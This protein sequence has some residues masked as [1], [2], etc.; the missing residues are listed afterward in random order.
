MQLNKKVTVDNF[1]ANIILKQAGIQFDAGYS[2][3]N[4]KDFFETKQ[5]PKFIHHC[6]YA[7]TSLFKCIQSEI[8]L[9]DPELNIIQKTIQGTISCLPRD[10]PIL[11]PLIKANMNVLNST[12]MNNKKLGTITTCI[13][14][15]P[16]VITECRTGAHPS[17]VRFPGQTP[18]NAKRINKIVTVD[19]K[20]PDWH[21]TGSYAVAGETITIKCSPQVASSKLI[22]VRIGCHSDQLHNC[23]GD[24]KR[25]PDICTTTL[26]ERVETTLSNAFG[27]LIYIDVHHHHDQHPLGTIHFELKNI[28]QAAYFILDKTTLSEWQS[29]LKNDN[30]APWSEF[31]SRN[32]I[33]TVPYS[34][35][36]T[37]KDP[38]SVLRT[39]DKGID[40]CAELCGKSDARH[41]PMRYVPDV[42]ISCGYMH[43]GYP[44]MC[45][46]DQCESDQLLNVKN[47]ISNWGLWHETGHNH[48]NDAWTPEGTVEV[49][50]NLFTI[51]VIWTFEGNNWS[52]M[53]NR[54]LYKQ[55]MEH[56]RREFFK[57][58]NFEHW[59]DEP[60]VGLWLYVELIEGFGFEPF[61]K[62]F[63]D[64]LRLSGVDLPK[65]NQ[66]KRDE[67]AMRFSRQVGRNICPLFSI[68][69][70]PIS[71]HVNK[72][73]SDLPDWS[74]AV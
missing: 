59:K 44:I 22:S 48:Q 30:I 56:H 14:S 71:Q 28:V 50:V 64:Y 11:L 1:G 68:W 62:V 32:A 57:S 74:P 15:S 16:M 20:I 40:L 58:P 65:S 33:I 38:T 39:W 42:Q 72:Q 9:S 23:S 66:Q 70:V 18:P 3:N 53:K 55:G 35:A 47:L 52:Q 17:H 8:H 4:G 63:R 7:L 21:S 13:T 49:T 27:G 24:L 25:A 45:H 36:K 61:K 29:T 34:Y 31:Q 10:D 69:H 41:R 67:W 26:I 73:L 2:E 54:L 19:T 51:Y 12:N 60:F 46:M 37:I 43:S 6:G 5:V